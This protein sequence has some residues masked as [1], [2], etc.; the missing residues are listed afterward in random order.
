MVL[1]GVCNWNETPQREKGSFVLNVTE[2]LKPLKGPLLSRRCRKKPSQHMLRFSLQSE[3]V[4]YHQQW[5]GVACCQERQKW[6]IQGSELSHP[7]PKLMTFWAK[8]VVR[9]V[10]VLLSLQSVFLKVRFQSLYEIHLVCLF[11]PQVM[12]SVFRFGRR[13]KQNMPLGCH[14]LVS[15]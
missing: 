4:M 8:S 10:W 14:C 9:C 5:S 2:L 6:C 1:Q 15:T 7:V 11:L 12:W 13:N 3:W